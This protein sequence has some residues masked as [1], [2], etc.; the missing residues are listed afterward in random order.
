M[1]DAKSVALLLKYKAIV[2]LPNT[3]NVTPFMA[4]AGIGQGFNPT[5]GRYKS[6][7]EA[8]ECVKILKDAGANVNGK[9]DT[10]L[11]ALHAAASLGWNNTIKTLV[12]DGAQLE[13]LDRNGMTPIDYAVGRQ[14]RGFLEPE[15]VRQD[16]SF[17]ILKDYIVASTGRA[18][19]DSA[20]RRTPSARG[21]W[22]Q[23][24]SP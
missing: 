24:C 13:A 9:T 23:R 14:E 18:S 19:G 12:A 3:N 15:H 10:G 8:A 1:G 22:R 4:A 7:D 11:T 6:D 5:R 2:D 17:T 16:A 21:R 20:C